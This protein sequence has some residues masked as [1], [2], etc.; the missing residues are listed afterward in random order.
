MEAGWED[1]KSDHAFSKPT[2]C[3]LRVFWKCQ[4]QVLFLKPTRPKLCRQEQRETPGKETQVALTQ[5]C[6]S[7]LL[8]YR[9]FKYAHP[10]TVPHVPLQFPPFASKTLGHLKPVTAHQH[11]PLAARFHVAFTHEYARTGSE[12]A[13]CSSCSASSLGPRGLNQ[14]SEGK[15]SHGHLVPSPTSVGSISVAS[16]LDASHTLPATGSLLVQS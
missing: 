2:G 14:V 3:V 5:L 13:L 8:K 16:L 6:P 10:H 9:C 15:G 1:W 7:C 12:V 4:S 11:S